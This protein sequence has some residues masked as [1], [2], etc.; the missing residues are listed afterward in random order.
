MLRGLLA[1]R[2]QAVT[3]IL[4][5]LVDDL[6]MIDGLPFVKLEQIVEYKLIR[7]IEKYQHHLE[8]LGQTD[9]ASKG[10]I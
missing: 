10:K 6:K 8:L 1:T 2:R 3:L 5:K 7:A 9:F 4:R